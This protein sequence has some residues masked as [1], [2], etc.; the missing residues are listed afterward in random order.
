[1][2]RTHGRHPHGSFAH[3]PSVNA[4]NRGSSRHS[5]CVLRE[6]QVSAPA[7]RARSH[8]RFAPVSR[9]AVEHDREDLQF[10][11]E[12]EVRCI[13]PPKLEIL[14]GGMT[15]GARRNPSRRR[16]VAPGCW[17]KDAWD[18]A[19]LAEPLALDVVLQGPGETPP[20]GGGWLRAAGGRAR[21]TRR[22]WQNPSR[23]TWCCRAFIKPKASGAGRPATGWSC[24]SRTSRRPSGPVPG[25]R[26]RWGSA[27][28]PRSGWLPRAGRYRSSQS[29]P[30]RRR[31]SSR[32]RPCLDQ[33]LR[34]SSRTR[35][36]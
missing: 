16:W 34:S 29:L 17:R 28:S 27:R 21:G 23:R 30:P 10:W 33:Q 3:A 15:A 25:R 2:T 36:R 19:L 4:E 8:Q 35:W 1:L 11:W 18:A 22:C 24:P 31:C 20:A 6:S 7:I 9:A 14:V 13:F 32:S 26:S 12:S 5:A